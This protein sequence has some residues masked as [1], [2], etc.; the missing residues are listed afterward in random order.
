MNYKTKRTFKQILSV[1]L[2]GLAAFGAVFGLV[3]LSEV[4]NAETEVIHP[5]F[6]VGGLTV[7]GKYE[8][9]DGSIY[10]KDSF[11]CQGMSVKLDFDSNVSYQAFFYDEL[12]KYISATAVY[13]ESMELEVPETAVYA[14]LEVTPTWAEDVEEEDRIVKWY[15]VASYANQVEISVLKDQS[16]REKLKVEIEVDSAHAGYYFSPDQE[17]GEPLVMDTPSV[18]GMVTSTLIDVAE[19]E[20]L[21]I[22]SNHPNTTY[23]YA[24]LNSAEKIIEIKTLR[25]NSDG[26]AKITL[27]DK[28]AYVRLVID[29]NGEYDAWLF[30]N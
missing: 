28:A 29:E 23:R 24:V 12:D 7:D 16:Y 13:G 27:P 3:K 21:S 14:R 11:E 20:Y 30:N 19:Y 17:K 2:A 6:S 25:Y 5:T 15:D 9:T 18:E 22:K 10:T 4:L 1:A 8:E 26:S